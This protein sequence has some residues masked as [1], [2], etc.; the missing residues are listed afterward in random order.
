MKKNLV[1]DDNSTILRIVSLVLENKGY[2]DNTATSD[3]EAY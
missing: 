2:E 3:E 1:V